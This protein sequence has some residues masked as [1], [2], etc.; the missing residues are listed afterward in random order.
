MNCYNHPE[1]AAVSSCIDCGKGLCIK[2]TDLYKMPICSDCNLKRVEVDKGSFFGFYVLSGI[3]FGLGFVI[4]LSSDASVV[5]IAMGLIVGLVYSGIPWGWRMLSS[6]QPKMFLVLPLV[7]WLVYFMLKLFLAMFVGLVAMPI[8]IVKAVS[9]YKK[10]K[11][12]KNN[13]ID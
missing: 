5:G 11:N 2:C 1:E 6:V 12:I 8:G 7:G 3:L 10:E 9:T 13:L 4:T